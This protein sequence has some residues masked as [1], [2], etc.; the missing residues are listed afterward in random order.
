M[1][2]SKDL[3]EQQAL[4]VPGEQ[5]GQSDLPVL[6]G[7]TAQLEHMV[8]LDPEVLKGYLEHRVLLELQETE[9]HKDHLAKLDHQELL[10]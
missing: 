7:I 9:E 8:L 6:L 3:L 4:L 2:E 5:L 1:L 10:A